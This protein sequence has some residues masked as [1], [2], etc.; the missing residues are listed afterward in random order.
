MVGTSLSSV[1]ALRCFGMVVGLL[2]GCSEYVVFAASK[3]P[4]GTQIGLRFTPLPEPKFVIPSNNTQC[5]DAVRLHTRQKPVWYRRYPATVE[6]AVQWLKSAIQSKQI[7]WERGRILAHLQT[8]ID[9]HQHGRMFLLFGN[10]HSVVEHYR[11]FNELWHPGRDG[12]Q[13]EG[14]TH[15]ALEAF[16]SSLQS[17]SLTPLYRRE[18]RRLWNSRTS[19][20]TPQA[21]LLWRQQIT[22]L[23]TTDQQPLIDLYLRHGDHWALYM[24]EVI[25]HFLLGQTYPREFVHEVHATLRHIRKHHPA[26]EIIASDMAQPLRKQSQR[27]MC[28]IYPLREMFSLHVVQ[29]RLKQRRSVIAY[30]WGSDH[31]RKDHLPRFLSPTDRVLAVHLSGGGFPGIWEQALAQLQIPPRMFAIPTPG[32][33]DGDFLIHLPPRSSMLVRALAEQAKLRAHLSRV[34]KSALHYPHKPVLVRTYAAKIHQALQR[35]RFDLSGCVRGVLQRTVLIQLEISGQGVVEGVSFPRTRF[36]RLHRQ[37]R[38]CLRQ[39]LWKRILQ[40]PPHHQSTEILFR[41][42]LFP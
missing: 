33:R 31:I 27:L 2:L 22:Q 6:G 32:A 36:A 34:P 40:K 8:A 14:V 21:R 37:Q 10:N 25:N 17:R 23:L 24:L 11:F 5:Y 9:H 29:R 35:L 7:L 30:M 19:L 16:V 26:V 3:K 4:S 18:L 42:H 20:T 15:I 12:I 38:R 41:L 13:L 1:C 39:R 28:W